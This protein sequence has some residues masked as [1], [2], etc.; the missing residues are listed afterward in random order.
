VWWKELPVSGVTRNPGGRLIAVSGQ[1]ASDG[2]G[3]IVHAG[4]PAA[5]A[6][7]ALEQIRAGLELLGAS[8]ADV[9]EVT[10]FHKDPRDWRVALEAGREVFAGGEP[11]WT[12]IGT[13][14]LFRE[15]YLH[16]IHALAVVDP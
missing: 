9:V 5:Q 12:S 15:G 1:V 7:Y 13:T 8:L 6:R 14:G 4:D 2:D 16:E 3:A 10:A 11:A